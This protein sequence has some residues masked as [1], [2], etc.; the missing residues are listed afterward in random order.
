MPVVQVQL[1]CQVNI[2]RLIVTG[3]EV[4]TQAVSLTFRCTDAHYGF[5]RCVVTRTG[6]ADNLHVFYF[7]GIQLL[8]FR[9]VAHLASVDVNQRSTFAEHLEPILLF[10]DTGNLA[11]HIVG[12]PCLAQY[13][14][15]YVGY[16]RIA[17][18]TCNGQIRFYHHFAQQ[19]RIRL[20]SDDA[21]IRSIAQF[22]R[23]GVADGRNTKKLVAFMGWQR[24]HSLLI[25]H[26]S[27][28]KCRIR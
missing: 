13:A 22:I 8:Q 4:E 3:A 7:I 11:Q 9:Q 1:V 20:Q 6:V 16:Q 2:F 23:R 25:A 26:R 18:H 28:N 15:L 17:L 19:L 5:H 21:Q 24:E 14:V 10:G 12:R 27:G